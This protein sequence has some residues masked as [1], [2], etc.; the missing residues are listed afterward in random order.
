[1]MRRKDKVETKSFTI[2]EIK[3]KEQNNLRRSS[4]DEGI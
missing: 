4:G 2:K 1:M 3:D